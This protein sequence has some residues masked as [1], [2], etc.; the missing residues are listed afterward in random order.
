V[1][2]ENSHSDL[3]RCGRLTESVAFSTAS[4]VYV[5]FDREP[6]EKP[7][8]VPTNLCSVLVEQSPPLE[9]AQ[10]PLLTN[11]FEEHV[12]LSDE[13][14]KGSNISEVSEELPRAPQAQKRACTV[15]EALIDGGWVLTRTKKN[16]KYTRRV[17][18]TE[19]GPAHKQTVTLSNTA[20]DW[21]AAR[22]AL[23]L[24]RRLNGAA[25][26][27]G[28]IVTC[29]ECNEEKSTGYFSMTQLKKGTRMKCRLV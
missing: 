5:H 10:T 3:A 20:S 13:S 6:A 25:L 23:S 26:V 24:L 27:R 2:F 17:K 22:N 7:T 18:L 9:K 11:T 29:S 28:A 19:D 1:N 14:E 12:S 15:E 4:L 16:I 21:R 8:P